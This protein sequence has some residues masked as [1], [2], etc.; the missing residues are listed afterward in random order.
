MPVELHGL[1]VSL[2]GIGKE[3]AFHVL[4]RRDF[5]NGLGADALVDVQD[6]RVNLE[7]LRLALAGPLQPR[8]LIPQC[9]GQRVGLIL[10]QRPLPGCR[11]QLRQLVWFARGIELKLRRASGTV[12]V[13]GLRQKGNHPLRRNLRRRNVL[14]L[15][16]LVPVI[17]HPR[18]RTVSVFGFAVTRLFAVLGSL[19]ALPCSYSPFHRPVS[20]AIAAATG[21]A[22]KR[23][24]RIIQYWTEE[25]SFRRLPDDILSQSL[26]LAWSGQ[27]GRGD[28]GKVRSLVSHCD[29]DIGQVRA[30]DSRLR[31][32]PLLEFSSQF[33]CIFRLTNSRAYASL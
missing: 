29:S 19:F 24:A 27:G 10:V 5:Q 21:I 30:L 18:Q 16:G 33:F 26:F 2:L 9:L 3:R 13:F 14:P 4:P 17:L 7:L 6:N 31:G 1:V 23:T 32:N 20:A 12:K 8:F 25:M 22:N 15:R 28:S 11:E